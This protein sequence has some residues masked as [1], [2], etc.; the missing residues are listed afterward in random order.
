MKK[1]GL[2]KKKKKK[3]ASLEQVRYVVAIYIKKNHLHYSA[4]I[5]FL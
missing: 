3:A 4:A 2:K 1:T 5:T